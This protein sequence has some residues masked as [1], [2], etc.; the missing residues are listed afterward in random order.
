MLRLRPPA[1]RDQNGRAAEV[2]RCPSTAAAAAMNISYRAAGSS[3]ADG[4]VT[5]AAI[6]DR[7]TAADTALVGLQRQHRKRC[8]NTRTCAADSAESSSSRR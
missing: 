4:A 8:L 2:D 3:G 6:R 7:P 1:A 5:R